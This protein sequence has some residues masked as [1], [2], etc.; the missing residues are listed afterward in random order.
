MH[1][2]S[3]KLSTVIPNALKLKK[4]T[5]STLKLSGVNEHA[6]AEH[7]DFSTLK[8]SRVRVSTLK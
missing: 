8:L 1:G 4:V 2:D 5:P 3:M 6:E 7:G